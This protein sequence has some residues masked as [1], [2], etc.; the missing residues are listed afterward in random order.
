MR[1]RI[2]VQVAFA[3]A[4][5][6]GADGAFTIGD[7]SF[8]NGKEHVFLDFET[9]G[10]G[11]PV[12]LGFKQ[13]RLMPTDEYA[14]FGVL[15]TSQWGWADI[16]TP[17]DPNASQALAVDAVGSWPTVIGGPGDTYRIDFTTPVHAFGIGVVQQGFA[18]QG[19]PSAEF[20]STITAFNADGEI[21]GI[22]R[23]WED[24]I[25]GGAGGAYAGGEYG[26]EWR[27][28]TYGF[29]GLATEEPI[30]MLEFTNVRDSIFDDLHFSAVPAPGAGAAF[31]LLGLGALARR[32]RSGV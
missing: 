24:L 17:P 12:G 31:G 30:A 14:A 19:E 15:F 11:S 13:A 32:R 4:L 1:T 22:V 18:D 9:R 6:A 27:I 29:L 7:R 21:L 25:D 26:E 23:L 5:C 8:F 3:L 10:D 16:G 28:F 20:T 2:C